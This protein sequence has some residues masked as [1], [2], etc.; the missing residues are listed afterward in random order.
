MSL[1][2]DVPLLILILQENFIRSIH[3]VLTSFYFNIPLLNLKKPLCSFQFSVLQ[4]DTIIYVENTLDKYFFSSKLFEHCLFFWREVPADYQ[5]QW[6]K[7]MLCCATPSC[8][9]SVFTLI[10]LTGRK[11]SAGYHPE[12]QSNLHL[13]L[14][15]MS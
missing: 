7:P 13:Q 9:H 2:A 12:L 4:R 5:L 8:F 6:H 1:L 3:S 10:S 15:F 14:Y 11:S